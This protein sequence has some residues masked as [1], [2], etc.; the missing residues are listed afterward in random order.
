LEVIVLN[1]SYS[2]ENRANMG[3]NPAPVNAGP[4]D[5]KPPLSN[6]FTVFKGLFIFDRESAP[7]EGEIRVQDCH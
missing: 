5:G 4:G 7:L 1:S 2:L 3:E 6:R